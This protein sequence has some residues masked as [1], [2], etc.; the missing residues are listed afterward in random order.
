MVRGNH[1]YKIGG[2][3]RND[4]MIYKDVTSAPIYT[5]SSA[6]TALP[7]LQSTNIGGGGIGLPYASFLL[8]LADSA[9]ISALGAPDNRKNSWGL[10]IQDTWKVSRN[11]TLDYGLRWDYQQAAYEMNY[12]NGMF[13]PTVPN[14]SAGGLLGGMVYE[15]YGPGRCNC[16]FTNTYPYALGPRLGVAYKINAK[17][18]FR[19]GWG[20]VYGGTPTGGETAAQGV[21]WNSLSFAPVSFG[22]PGANLCH[23]L[24]LQS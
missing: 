24:S 1:T 14:P 22:Q 6:E 4:P 7:Y 23:W 10:Y 5:F 18:V 12:R 11:L 16:R 21:G 2:E 15:G 3:W 20:L 9:S 19:G 8:G 13:G 17:T